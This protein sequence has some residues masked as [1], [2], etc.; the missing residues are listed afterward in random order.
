LLLT[1]YHSPCLFFSFAKVCVGG[2]S[3]IVFR[4]RQQHTTPFT[5]RPTHHA[6]VRRKRK[7]RRKVASEDGGKHSQRC[8]IHSEERENER[9]VVI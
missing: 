7:G 4:G 2:K 1:S 3:V 6:V 5:G 8:V 9:A